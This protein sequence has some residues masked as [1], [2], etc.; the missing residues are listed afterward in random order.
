[1]RVEGEG[2]SLAFLPDGWLISCPFPEALKKMIE[3]A[4]GA[5]EAVE[6]RDALS[7]AHDR[8]RDKHGQGSNHPTSRPSTPPDTWSDPHIGNCAVDDNTPS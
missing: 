2:V 4:E 1:M 7:E 8:A 5:L 3:I 6:E